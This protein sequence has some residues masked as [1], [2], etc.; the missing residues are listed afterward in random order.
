MYCVLD[1][2]EGKAIVENVSVSLLN[3]ITYISRENHRKNTT[4]TI[5]QNQ[6]SGLG[7]G[8]EGERDQVVKIVN[9]RNA[10]NPM[11]IKPTARG[12][13]LKST[14]FL[15]VEAVLSASCTCCSDLPVVRQ[16]ILIYPWIPVNNL[17]QQ[18][19]NW[20]PEV[21]QMVNISVNVEASNNNLNNMNNPYS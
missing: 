16:P 21:M 14:Y 10:Q 15:K 6:F 20:Q 7:A 8:E 2:K 3:E 18:P 17:F 1:N 11:D 19:S 9:H 13:N 4:Y 5:F 12:N